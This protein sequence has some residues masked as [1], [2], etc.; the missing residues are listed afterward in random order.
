MKL[1]KLNWKLILFFMKFMTGFF[2]IN[3]IYRYALSYYTLKRRQA[4]RRRAF[5]EARNMYYQTHPA[6]NNDDHN[7]GND[8]NHHQ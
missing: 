8:D 4:E 6:F 2:I 1:L 3:I 7:H 5:I